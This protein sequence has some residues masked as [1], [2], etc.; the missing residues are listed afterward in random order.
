M[1]VYVCV[2]FGSIHKTD[3]CMIEM[4]A[5]AGIAVCNRVVTFKMVMRA[6]RM[7]RIMNVIL[8]VPVLSRVIGV[9]E[10]ECYQGSVDYSVQ[11]DYSAH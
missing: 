3:T 10:F 6:M 9:I 4:L 11:L 7:I 8:I 5:N 2:S 1:C